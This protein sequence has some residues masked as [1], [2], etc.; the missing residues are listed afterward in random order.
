MLVDFKANLAD[1]QA[2]EKKSV[3][4]FESLK[5]AKEEEIAASN[6][7]VQ[8]IDASDA[9]LRE[10]NAQENKELSD[11][12]EQLGMDQTFLADL[13][14]KCAASDAEF[15]KRMKSRLEEITAVE[16]TI[17]ILNSDEAF[18]NFDKTTRGMVED[19]K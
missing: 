19:Q 9:A 2:A 7:L 3:E 17:G 16:E 11:T 1:A 13:K 6:K 12:E 15:E 4:S 14:E 8:E 18:A 5:V 10:K